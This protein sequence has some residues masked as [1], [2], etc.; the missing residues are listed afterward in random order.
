MYGV[1]VVISLLIFL[2]CILFNSILCKKHIWRQRGGYAGINAVWGTIIKFGDVLHKP[3]VIRFIGPKE[4]LDLKNLY[5]MINGYNDSERTFTNKIKQAVKFPCWILGNPS[6]NDKSVYAAANSVGLYTDPLFT[7]SNGGMCDMDSI[8]S[9]LI[10]RNNR[11]HYDLNTVRG[12]LQRIRQRIITNM[13]TNNT[14]FI[15]NAMADVSQGDHKGQ[16]AT[17]YAY[18]DDPH[19][20]Y[21]PLINEYIKGHE[22][23]LDKRGRWRNV[24]IDHFSNYVFDNE[25]LRGWYGNP[26][27]TPPGEVPKV[28]K[29]MN[30]QYIRPSLENDASKTKKLTLKP[31]DKAKSK[32][33]TDDMAD[34]IPAA[35]VRQTIMLYIKHILTIQNKRLDYNALYADLSYISLLCQLANAFGNTTHFHDYNTGLSDEYRYTAAPLI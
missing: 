16:S 9:V 15:L 34:I 20:I 25:D 27:K 24:Q 1:I 30:P 23:R 14:L 35:S 3:L 2:T 17:I 5:D 8:L 21:A 11:S 28:Y 4:Q 12:N 32:R 10:R 29:V 26:G 7:A 33:S 13:N 31:A 18:S 19:L 22:M 6:L